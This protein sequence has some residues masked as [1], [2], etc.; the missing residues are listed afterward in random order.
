[1]YLLR[2]NLTGILERRILVIYKRFLDKKSMNTIGILIN[3]FIY[4][5]YKD[6]TFNFHRLKVTKVFQVK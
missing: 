3:Q 1:M 5:I 4:F 2:V 6:Y